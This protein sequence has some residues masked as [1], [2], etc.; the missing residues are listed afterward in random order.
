MTVSVDGDDV[1]DGCD[2]VDGV[3]G[4][5]EEVG[6]VA[7]GDQAAVCAGAAGLGAVLLGNNVILCGVLPGRTGAVGSRVAPRAR[8]TPQGGSTREFAS[9]E[10]V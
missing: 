1:V 8:S 10:Q 4:D 2:V 5:G 7:D 6:V 3:A 9:T